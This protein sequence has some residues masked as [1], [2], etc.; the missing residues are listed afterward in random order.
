MATYEFKLGVLLDVMKNVEDSDALGIPP[1][2]WTWKDGAV[3][4]YAGTGKAYYDGYPQVEWNFT[5]LRDSAWA[6]LMGFFLGTYQYCD[7]YIK[8]KD[9]SGS[10]VTKKAIMHKPIIGESCERGVGGWFGVRLMF[11]RIEST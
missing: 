7:V 8:T 3:R 11:T 5:Y 4:R 6:W 9:N 10:Y 1:H 2:P